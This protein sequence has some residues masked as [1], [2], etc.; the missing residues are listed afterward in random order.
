MMK[1]T[2]PE[3]QDLTFTRGD[4]QKYTE[5]FDLGMIVQRFVL[6]Q[7]VC[8]EKANVKLAR[9]ILKKLPQKSLLKDEEHEALEK[10]MKLSGQQI[11]PDLNTYYLEC[12]DAVYDAVQVNGE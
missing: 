6:P 1:I 11:A 2:Y 5:R 8:R 12:L 9:S 10:W 3:P 4:G 7:E